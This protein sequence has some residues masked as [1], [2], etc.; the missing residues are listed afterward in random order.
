MKYTL[1]LV[2]L[3]SAPVMANPY[4][5][6][7]NEYELKDWTHTKTVDHM[8]FGYQADDTIGRPYF[9]IGP[10]THGYSWEAGYKFNLPHHL[11]LKGKVETKDQKD[12]VPSTKIET[13]LRWTW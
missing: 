7:K 4:V 10:M 8:R 11:Q 5:E 1:A 13:E 3:I 12:K 6:Y 2:A 9:E